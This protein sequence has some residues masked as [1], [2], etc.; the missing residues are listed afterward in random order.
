[1]AYGATNNG[2]MVIES[3]ITE[4]RYRGRGLA[5]RALSAL[6]DWAA[7]RSVQAVCLQVEATNERGMRLYRRLG[8]RQKLYRYEYRRQP[9]AAACTPDGMQTG[10][11]TIR[12]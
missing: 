3:V 11:D 6:I 1:M 12:K 2:V 7:S 10:V 5:T 8:L 9:G 4:A